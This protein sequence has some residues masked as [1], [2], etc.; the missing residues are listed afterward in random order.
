M[1]LVKNGNNQ[2]LL[3]NTNG[4]ILLN[5]TYVRKPCFYGEY[6]P[7]LWSLGTILLQQFSWTMDLLSNNIFLTN[8]S[9]APS[10]DREDALLNN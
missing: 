2:Y 5:E 3:V 7:R 8:Y 4:N 1:H 10:E 9:V 6:K